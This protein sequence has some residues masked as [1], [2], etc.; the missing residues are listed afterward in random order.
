VRD[1]KGSKNAADGS[2]ARSNRHKLC[3]L[4]VPDKSDPGHKPE[5]GR[6]YSHHCFSL[7]AER[8]EEVAFET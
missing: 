2:V 8:R 4:N 1:P 7:I 6:S 3:R 5:Q